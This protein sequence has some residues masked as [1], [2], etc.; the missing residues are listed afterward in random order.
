MNSQLAI[1]LQQNSVKNIYISSTQ[2]ILNVGHSRNCLFRDFQSQLNSI[3]LRLFFFIIGIRI[4]SDQILIFNLK[5]TFAT[6]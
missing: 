6:T 3:L 5:K 4:R 1:F 2:N